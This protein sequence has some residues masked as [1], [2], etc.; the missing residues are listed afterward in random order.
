[1]PGQQGSAVAPAIDQRRMR[2]A[3]ARAA[4]SFDRGDF[5]QTVVRERLIERLDLLDLEPGRVLD[6]GSGTGRAL[7]ALAGRFPGSM[8]LALD[9]VPEML[10]V[11]AKRHGHSSGAVCGGAERLPLVDGSVDLVFS[12]LVI[13]WC[14][15]YAQVFREVRRVLRHPGCFTF[16]TLGPGS[17]TELREAW[18]VVDEAAH[19]IQ[20]PEMHDLGDA[21]VQAGMTEAVIDTERLTIN[22]ADLRQLTNDLKATGTSNSSSRRPRGLTG[23]RAWERFARAYEAR[24]DA[25]GRLPVTLELVYGQAWVPGGSPALAAATS[26][27]AEI[28][29]PVGRLRRWPGPR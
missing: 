25:A 27:S 5:L 24:R 23:R 15:S 3:F 4:E 26:G 11:S 16:T 1:M 8:L 21:L 10:A 6:L 19:V 2:A 14:P 29:F 7:P 28:A 12:N 20:F 13:H 9:L 18:A 22:Y 17:F